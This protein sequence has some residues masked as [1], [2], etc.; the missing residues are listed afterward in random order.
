MDQDPCS[1]E[2]ERFRR[3]TEALGLLRHTGLEPSTEPI[4]R[5][6]DVKA[7]SWTPEMDELDKAATLHNNT[8]QKEYDEAL[9]ALNECQSRQ[10]NKKAA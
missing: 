2:Q 7:V 8:I 1:A 10:K 4:P 6:G 9:A 5:Q 3:A